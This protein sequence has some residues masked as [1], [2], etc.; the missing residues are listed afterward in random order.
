MATDGILDIPAINLRFRAFVNERDW[1]QFHTPKNLAMALA[2]EAGELMEIFQWL[3]P[4]QSQT[5]MEDPKCAEAVRHELADVLVYVL[6]MA[7]VLRVD[8]PEA[9]GEKMALNAEKYPVALAKGH[10]RKCTELKAEF[11]DEPDG[12]HGKTE[13]P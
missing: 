6:R 5:V 7:D 2:K 12:R 9:V 3:T 4:E 8:L 1:E 10:A 13:R 11:S